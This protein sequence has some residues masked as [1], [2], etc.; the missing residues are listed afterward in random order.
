MIYLDT[1]ALAKLVVREAE[2]A[3]LREW[4]DAQRDTYLSSALAATELHR[5]VRRRAPSASP[6]AQQVIDALD[7]VPVGDDVVGLAGRLDPPG[8]RTLDAIHLASALVTRAVVSVFVAYDDRLRAAA[9]QSG[10]RVAAPG[11]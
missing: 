8:L 2:T 7:L 3:A 6:V 11:V 1:S 5:A 10:L 9:A 4:L